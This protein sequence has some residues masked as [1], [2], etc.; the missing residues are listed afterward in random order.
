[1]TDISLKPPVQND[2]RVR[3]WMEKI[4]TS[5]FNL[6]VFSTDE[7]PTNQIWLG[8]QVYRKV[9]SLGALPNATETTDAHGLTGTY[10]IIKMYGMADDGSKGEFPLPYADS[11][12]VANSVEV[13]TNSADIKIKTGANYSGYTG[14]IVLEYIKA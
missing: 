5:L 4:A 6:Q 10:T 11:D 8:E 14:Y 1:M 7:T 2:F 9:V 13:K 3:K 12:D